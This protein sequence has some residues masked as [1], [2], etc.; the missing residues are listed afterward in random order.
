M[1][2]GIDSLNMVLEMNVL[3]GICYKW[4]MFQPKYHGVEIKSLGAIQNRCRQL[5]P[6]NIHL[7]EDVFRLR[8]QKTS[9]RRLQDA[10]IKTNIFALLIRLQ[11][12]S[13]RR[14]EDIL[15]K[16]NILVLVI[17]HQDV[18]KTSSRRLAKT[19]QNVFKTSSRRLA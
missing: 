14:L 11:K 2:E 4:K 8:F 5:F 17:R 1:L 15:I 12:T 10:V 3:N 16:T 18:F 6:A 9:S 13:S 19:L 7:D